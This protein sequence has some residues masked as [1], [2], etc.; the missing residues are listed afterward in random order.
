MNK[1]SFPMEISDAAVQIAN[2]AILAASDRCVICA[3]FKG[4]WQ[5]SETS[6]M[7]SYSA[8]RQPNECVENLIGIFNFVRNHCRC[9]M[10]AI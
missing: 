2:C 10:K 8:N 9:A 6:D 7:L 4:F 1:S 3:I 5:I